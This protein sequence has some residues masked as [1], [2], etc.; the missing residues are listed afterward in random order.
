MAARG[1]DIPLLQNVI[2]FDFPPNMKLFIHRSG[3]TARAG[4][5]GSSYALITTDEMAYLHDL[6]IFV[7]KKYVDSLE[8]LQS[9]NQ[10]YKSEEEEN[11]NFL[12]EKNISFEDIIENP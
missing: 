2:H 3:R 1:I 8:S 9:T 4:Q 10:N 12:K 5:K 7:G 6:S 11:E